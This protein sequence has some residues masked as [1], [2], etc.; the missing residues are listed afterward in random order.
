M[1]QILKLVTGKGTV[2][3]LLTGYLRVRTD[4]WTT[5]SYTGEGDPVWDTFNL[6]GR[7][8]SETLLGSAIYGV[9]QFCT[10]ARRN[11]SN[12]SWDNR[13]WLGWKPEGGEEIR[14]LVTDGN[15]V[16]QS[17]PGAGGLGPLLNSDGF[18]YGALALQHMPWWEHTSNVSGTLNQMGVCGSVWMPSITSGDLPGRISFFGIDTLN[19]VTP[20]NDFWIG[21]RPTYGG[22]AT[23]NP[24]WECEL[25]TMGTAGYGSA[26]AEASSSNGTIMRTNFGGTAAGAGAAML[27]RLRISVYQ[28]LGTEFTDD[29]VGKYLVLAR[30]KCGASTECLVD[31]YQG[32][33][34]IGSDPMGIELVGETKVTNTVYKLIELGQVQIPPF[35]IK[36]FDS[37]VAGAMDTNLY[38][39][40]QRLSGTSTLSIDCLILIPSEH[41]LTIKN[42]GI[43]HADDAIYF[44]SG[45]DGRSIAFTY[46]TTSGRDEIVEHTVTD[47]TWPNDGAGIVVHAA[48]SAT[49]DHD[50]T[51]TVRFIMSV[52]PRYSMIRV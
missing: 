51:G 52:Y 41:M 24:L 22:T 9:Q 14:T 44:Y 28:A 7:G 45:P 32:L 35:G 4:G 3:D 30:M 25:G 36:M 34:Q 15:L 37:G 26:V 47:F 40:A 2:M 42:A 6:V 50:I 31:L 10:E 17:D 8:T 18:V 16:I 43:N 21:I 13:S 5:Q 29:M 38:I 48:Q 20:L 33:G 1:A 27:Q 11:A 12:T 49:V 23:F 19:G 46:D 39:Y